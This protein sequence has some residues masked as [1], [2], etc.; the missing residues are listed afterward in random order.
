MIQEKK[1]L[2][3]PTIIYYQSKQI[4][5]FVNL[6]FIQNVYFSGSF[7]F[8]K[9]FPGRPFKWAQSLAG[10]KFIPNKLEN[11]VPK[12]YSIETIFQQIRKRMKNWDVLNTQLDLL[13]IKNFENSFIDSNNY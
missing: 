12:I 3:Y 6:I 10:L 4:Y 7:S 13:S 11:F 9:G 8:D 2:I 1:H 5:N